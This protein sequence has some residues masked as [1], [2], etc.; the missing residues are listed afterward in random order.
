MATRIDIAIRRQAG[1]GVCPATTVASLVLFIL[2]NIYLYK[3]LG[4]QF[5]EYL[6][7]QRH[8]V[9][10]FIFVGMKFQTCIHVIGK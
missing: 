2:K 10:S 8:T 1:A 7:I 4:Y 6:F 9:K 5:K 3:D